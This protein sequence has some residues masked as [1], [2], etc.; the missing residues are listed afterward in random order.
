[1]DHEK[2]VQLAISYSRS[3]SA[4]LVAIV[5]P[6]LQMKSLLIKT[7]RSIISQTVR[8]KL[9]NIFAVLDNLSLN[10]AL[11]VVHLLPDRSVLM[12]KFLFLSVD[13]LSLFSCNLLLT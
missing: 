12:R 7:S 13:I 9:E 11:G 5:P 4:L 6:T 10:Q 3:T 1:M 8:F 2:Q